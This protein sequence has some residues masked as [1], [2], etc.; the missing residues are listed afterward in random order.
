[1]TTPARAP[2]G[3]ALALLLALASLTGSAST[4][5]TAGVATVLVVMVAAGWPGLLELPSAR[6]SSLVIG[7]TGVAGVVLAVIAPPAYPPMQAVATVCA[8]GVFASFVHEMVRRERRD[9][10]ASLTGTVAGVMLA[11]MA[12]CWVRAQAT[13]LEAARAAASGDAAIRAAAANGVV[14]VCAVALCASLLVLSLPRP[15]IPAGRRRSIAAILVAGAVGAL[16]LAWMDPHAPLMG[17]VV[18]L[19]AGIGSTGAHVLLGSVLGARRSLPSLALAA[20]PVA[21]VGV[22]ALLAARWVV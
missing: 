4:A 9:L 15:Q 21:T 16:L 17:A 11:G 18:G 8:L 13:S 14:A 22:I 19:L 7:A 12:T 6:G 10:T 20:A 2:L 5:V 3:A 1:M